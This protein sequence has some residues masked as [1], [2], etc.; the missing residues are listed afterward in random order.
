MKLSI[1]QLV[2]MVFYG[3]S[4]F[5]IIAVCTMPISIGDKVIHTFAWVYLVLI[6]AYFFDENPPKFLRIELLYDK[7]LYDKEYLDKLLGISHQSLSLMRKIQLHEDYR[8]VNNSIEE[9]RQKYL[10]LKRL[11]PPSKYVEKH[12]EILNDIDGFLEG[13]KE[14]DYRLAHSQTQ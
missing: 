4:I 11:S 1:S 12:D 9:L 13:L 2:H 3:I 10:E 14:G 6:Y 8:V 5:I 7:D